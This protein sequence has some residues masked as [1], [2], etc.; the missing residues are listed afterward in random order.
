M[1]LLLMQHYVYRVVVQQAVHNR[2]PK[3]IGRLAV[4][5]AVYRYTW[6]ISTL[7]HAMQSLI[8]Q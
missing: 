7:A 1:L 3:P 5:Y 8:F 6:T 4:E 2:N